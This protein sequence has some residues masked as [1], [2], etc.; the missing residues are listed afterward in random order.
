MGLEDLRK[1]IDAIDADIVKRLNERYKLVM[2]VGKWKRGNSRAVYVPE[3]EK[4]LLERLE[5]LNEG[6]MTTKALRAIYREIMSGAISL[7]SPIRVACPGSDISLARAAAMARFGANVCCLSGKTLGEVFDDVAAERADYGVVPVENSLNGVFSETLD[8]F[9]DSRVK[10]CAEINVDCRYHLLAPSQ[11]TLISTVHGDKETLDECAKWLADNLPQAT[12]SVAANGQEAY[13]RTVGD[14]HGAMVGTELAAESFS[15][16][17]IRPNIQGKAGGVTRFLVLGRQ[18]PKPTG[19]DKTSLCFLTQNRPGA[20][21]D[22]FAPFKAEEI[23]ITMLESRP[24][25][26]RNWEYY[27][28]VDIVGHS[29]D[30]RLAKA[31]DE[32]SRQCL[33]ARV[34]GSY[35]RA[36]S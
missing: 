15:L 19:D 34:L 1:Q 5:K 10:I 13:E 25:H 28:F 31:I 36:L 16:Q 29:G 8:Q 2:E 22:A 32:L 30:E 11:S 9:V 12:L 23:A 21:C 35:P 33:T 7:E 20:L 17:V 24:S 6:P 26:R 3:R 18:E 4:A 27:F 14:P